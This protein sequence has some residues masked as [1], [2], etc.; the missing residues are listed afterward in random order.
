MT[1]FEV[2]LALLPIDMSRREIFGDGRDRRRLDAESEQPRMVPISFR[3][4]LQ[5]CLRDKALPTQRDQPA[6]V[7]MLGMNAPETHAGILDAEGQLD[8][9]RRPEPAE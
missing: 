6:R 8:N 9:T 2:D 7:E 5:D 3:R 1:P 4:L